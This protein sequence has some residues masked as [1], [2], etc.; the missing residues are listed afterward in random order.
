MEE[1]EGVV[2]SIWQR[3]M[4]SNFTFNCRLVNYISFSLSATTPAYCSSSQFTCNNGNCEP[5]SYKCD[6]YD[7]C[8]D[9]SDEFGCGKVGC[10]DAYGNGMSS[11]HHWMGSWTTSLLISTSIEPHPL[12]CAGYCYSYH[13]Q[14]FNEQ[15]TCIDA[16]LACN[17]VS[18]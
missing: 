7:D 10:G 4:A 17:R 16:T 5:L 14:C 13:F 11:L 15:C 6:D 1:M 12:L 18:N 9:N 3:S 2:M 8:G